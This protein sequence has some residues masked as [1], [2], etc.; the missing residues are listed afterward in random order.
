MGPSCGCETHFLAEFP[1]KWDSLDPRN[2]RATCSVSCWA[3]GLAAGVS[4]CRLL[5]L[6]HSGL[7]VQEAAYPGCVLLYV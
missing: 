4:T 1:L 3:C 2:L 7:K 5:F 6:G